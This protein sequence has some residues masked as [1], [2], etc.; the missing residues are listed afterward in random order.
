MYFFRSN[1][2]GACGGAV[3]LYSFMNG[4]TLSKKREHKDGNDEGRSRMIDFV[5]YFT[6]TIKELTPHCIGNTNSLEQNC[7]REYAIF[8]FN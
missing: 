2:C 8:F 7:H 3:C 1:K 4:S 6:T 5:F